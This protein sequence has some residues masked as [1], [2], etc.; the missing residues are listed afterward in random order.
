[1][2]NGG[3]QDRRTVVKVL[4]AALG[5]QYEQPANSHVESDRCCAE[6]PDHRVAEQVN[7]AVV[8]HP[9]VLQTVSI[10]VN[11][12]E[13]QSTYNSAAKTWPRVRT[14]VVGMAV[15]KTGVGRPHD[16]LQLKEFGQEARLAVV[17]LLCVLRYYNKS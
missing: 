5:T 13:A 10:I 4:V 12:C 16:L 14:R 17:H 1:M 6:P 2:R 7:L 9:E 15:G 3:E 8:L 11:S